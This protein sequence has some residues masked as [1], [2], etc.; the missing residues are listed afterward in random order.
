[1]KYKQFF[2]GIL[3]VT[4]AFNLSA[5]SERD[6][7]GVIYEGLQNFSHLATVMGLD[8]EQSLGTIKEVNLTSSLLSAW[9]EQERSKCN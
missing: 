2:C 3:F 6:S 4:A 9:E 5:H 8:L 7:Q 1:M